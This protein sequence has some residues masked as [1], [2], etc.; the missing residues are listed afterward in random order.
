[1][2]AI[3]RAHRR[4]LLALVL[5]LC[6]AVTFLALHPVS[7]AQAQTRCGNEFYY[8]SDA[9]YTC[10]VGYEVWDCDCYY[11]SWGYRTVYRIIVPL[12]YC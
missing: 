10:Q 8:Y 9:T 3:V 7:Q 5:A 11:S 2:S 1:M 12:E 4:P 6:L